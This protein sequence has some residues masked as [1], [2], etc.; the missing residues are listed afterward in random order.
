MRILYI[1]LG[2]SI[3]SLLRYVISNIQLDHVNYF[4]IQTL[5]INILGSCLLPFIVAFFSSTSFSKSVG[6]QGITVGFIGSFTTFS[7]F[8]YEFVFLYENGFVLYAIYYFIGSMVF[9]T[10]FGMLSLQLGKYLNKKL[11]KEEGAH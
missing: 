2:G 7:S 4:P 8:S 11:G 6:F 1:G 10:L 5:S 3:G 9:C